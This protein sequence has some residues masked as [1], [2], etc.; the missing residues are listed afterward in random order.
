VISGE[1][2]EEFL[3]NMED[4][5]FTMATVYELLDKLESVLISPEDKPIEYDADL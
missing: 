4:L 2:P 5:R 3:K 1:N